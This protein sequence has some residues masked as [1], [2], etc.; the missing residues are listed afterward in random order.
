MFVFVCTSRY[1][2]LYPTRIQ[3]TKLTVSKDECGIV[4]HTGHLLAKCGDEVKKTIQIQRYRDEIEETLDKVK[5]F[6]MQHVSYR[7][8]YLINSINYSLN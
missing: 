7:Y 1:I 4:H 8:L 6:K 3:N 5:E 2:E